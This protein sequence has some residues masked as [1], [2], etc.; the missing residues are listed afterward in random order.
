[1]LLHSL[2]IRSSRCLRILQPPSTVRLFSFTPNQRLPRQFS[3]YELPR[4]AP[5]TPIPSFRE[6]V[7]RA[8][9][10]KSFS[11]QVEEPS[12]RNQILVSIPI[13]PERGLVLTLPQFFVLGS[14]VVFSVAARATNEDTFALTKRLSE[15]S[16]LWKVRAPTNEEMRRA[17]QQ[18]LGQVRAA[19]SHHSSR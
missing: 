10:I 5:P 14:F 16:I 13:L 6:E 2:P 18:E 12:I 11:E 9:E 4:R 7:A 17:R 3:R 19:S 15:T 1:M 8:S